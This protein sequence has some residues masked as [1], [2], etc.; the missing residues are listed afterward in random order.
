MSESVLIA[1]I[2]SPRVSARLFLSILSRNGVRATTFG[3]GS[4][5]LRG[6]LGRE[7]RVADVRISAIMPADLLRT[8]ALG[9]LC[10]V[11]IASLK[12]GGCK[13]RANV[14]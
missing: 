12:R 5:R 9:K 13:S 3:Y 8:R 1:I 14:V 11:T 2:P 7:Y 6:P 4:A 10:G